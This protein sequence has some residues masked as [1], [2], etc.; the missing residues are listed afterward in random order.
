MAVVRA[1]VCATFIAASWVGLAVSPDAVG[2]QSARCTDYAPPAPTV[3][4]TSTVAGGTVTMT[5]V[6]L[7]GA[8]VTLTLKGAGLADTPL[9][10]AAADATGAFGIT[11]TI[12]TGI[13]PG[14]YQIIAAAAQCP[15]PITVVVV[16]N[17]RGG[18]QVTSTTTTVAGGSNI[19]TTTVQG[20]G[21]GVGGTT[22]TLASSTAD[23]GSDVLSSTASPQAATASAT[24][25]SGLAFTG[26][27]LRPVIAIAIAAVAIGALLIGS[28]RRRST[29]TGS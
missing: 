28:S 24:P 12:P 14:T 29:G 4:P 17:G 11:V 9:G 2:A 27:E 3:Q 26:G 18:S 22:T 21:G 23:V 20:G 6:A 15:Q 7:P 1:A 8:I 19:A 13:P 25:A 5:G 16:V 10:S